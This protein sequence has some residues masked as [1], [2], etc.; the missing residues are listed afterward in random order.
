MLSELMGYIY[1]LPFGICILAATFTSAF[2]R[3]KLWENCYLFY[4]KFILYYGNVRVY[5]L[6]RNGVHGTAW[7]SVFSNT[8]LP[9]SW[10]LHTITSMLEFVQ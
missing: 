3:D 8:S 9:R 7:S 1:I 6:R 2:P 5:E 4:K 10:Y